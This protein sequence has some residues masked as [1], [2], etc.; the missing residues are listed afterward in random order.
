MV[1]KLTPVKIR[2][3][4][5]T[6]DKAFTPWLVDNIDHLN[7]DIGLNIRDP[8]REEK[9]VNFYVDIVAEDDQGKV[10]I[11]N[12]FNNSDHDHLGKLITYLSNVADTKK[13]IWIV[14]DAKAEHVRAVEWLNQNS[15]TCLFYLVKI[16]IFKVDNSPPAARFDL[17]SGPDEE[18]IAIGKSKNEDSKRYDQRYRFWS[19]FIEKSKQKTNLYSNISPGR[20]SWI[21]TSSGVRGVN[22]NCSVLK[23][24][25]QCEIYIDRGK[26]EDLTNKKLF[27]ELL[28]DKDE[29]E[30][31]F[32][33][34]LI[35]ELLPNS[36]ASRISAPTNV[37]GWEDEESWENVHSELIEICIKIENCFSGK[38]KNLTSLLQN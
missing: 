3:V 17:I 33:G 1:F 24:K 8:Q 6:E 14:E 29:I 36:R 23:S 37:G 31:N 22:I 13:A 26:G 34:E 2:D 10:I 5:A 20:Y 18:T 16:Q 12:Q 32:G 21:G 7:D 9:L 28:K 15:E 35:W 11:E 25:A 27:N 38:I 30:K 19:L 4:W